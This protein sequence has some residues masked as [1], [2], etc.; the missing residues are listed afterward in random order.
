MIHLPE[1]GQ[2]CRNSSHSAVTTI[3]IS[4]TYP[5]YN[6]LITIFHHDP[7]P[8]EAKHMPPNSPTGLSH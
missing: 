1:T 7:P 6:L 3:Q 8:R 2:I 4:I 5:T